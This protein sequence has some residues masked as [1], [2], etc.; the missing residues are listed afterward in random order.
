MNFNFIV[1]YELLQI[2]FSLDEDVDTTEREDG[3]LQLKFGETR[4]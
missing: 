3:Q 2:L 1:L 4:V